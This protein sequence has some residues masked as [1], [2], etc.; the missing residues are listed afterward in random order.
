M[1]GVTLEKP[2]LAEVAAAPQ[3]ANAHRAVFQNVRI[4]PVQHVA[5]K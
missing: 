5:V 2:N 3:G 1:A 4:A